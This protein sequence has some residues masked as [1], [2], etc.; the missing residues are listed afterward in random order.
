VVVGFAEEFDVA[1]VGERVEVVEDFGGVG[2]ELFDGGA[3][4][5]EGEAET[6]AGLGDEVE[7][8]FREREVAVLGDAFGD[9][10]V[11]GIVEVGGVGVEDGVFPETEGLVD[12]EVEA[13]FGHCS[14]IS[15]GAGMTNGER[16]ELATDRHRQTRT[17]VRGERAEVEGTGLR[18]W[19]NVIKSG[20]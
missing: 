15:E 18:E 14:M 11:E 17:K 20:G 12:L 9:A 6:A 10:G 13:D 7:E 2:F 5:R 16:R 1:G 3:G 19:G 8:G 4:D